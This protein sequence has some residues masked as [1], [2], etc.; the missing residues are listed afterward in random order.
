VLILGTTSSFVGCVVPARL[1][2]V[3]AAEQTESG[4]TV[5]ND[6]LVAVV[7][8]PHN[9]AEFLS[10][11]GV[12]EQRVT[13]IEQFFVAYNLLEGLASGINPGCDLRRSKMTPRLRASPDGR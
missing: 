3:L 2:G 10:L 5:R 12:H 4:R 9:P 1:T 7:E 11:G 13:E 8:T 6:R